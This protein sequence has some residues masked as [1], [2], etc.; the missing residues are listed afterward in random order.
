M[1]V[2]WNALVNQEFA[3]NTVE[4]YAVAAAL[5]LGAVLAL[6]ILKTLVVGRLQ[7]LAART[8][9]DLDDFMVGLLQH[10]IG[11]TVYILAGLYLVAESLALPDGIEQL[12]HGVLVVVVTV[13]AVQLLHE[14]VAFF[15]VRWAKRTAADDPTTR[16]VMTN[17]GKVIQVGLW[18]GGAIFVLDNLGVNVTSVVAGLGIG[19]VAVALAAQAMLGDAFSSLAI[20]LDKPFK[21]GDFI[22]V[23]DLL[24]TVE[25][26]GVKT[27]RIRSLHG[28]QLIFP[29]SDL[30]SSRVRNYKRM[31]TRRIAFHIGVT[32]QTTTEQVRAIP[33][34]LRAVVEAQEHAKFDRAHFQAFGDFALTFEIVY[35]VLSPDYNVYMDVQQVINVGIKEAFDQAGIEFAYPTQVL[36]LAQTTGGT[37]RPLC[38]AEPA[39]R[40]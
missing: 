10:H 40:K 18:L 1:T 6:P 2:D 19:G 14:S 21:V 35:Y 22:I 36:Y 30:T 27:T 29:N 24:G 39:P 7:R 38:A 31:D 5:F 25:H 33:G 20:F 28:E 23:G 3:G 15:L 12:V 16:A 26:I 37:Q 34:M 4:A 11:P 32:Y 17:V 9:T 13:K 8:V